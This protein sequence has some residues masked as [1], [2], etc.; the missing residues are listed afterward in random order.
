MDYNGM[1]YTH[2]LKIPPTRYLFKGK[3]SLAWLKSP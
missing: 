2:D 1:G 3:E